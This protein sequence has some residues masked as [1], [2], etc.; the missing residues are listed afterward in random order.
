MSK[1]LQL[2]V[3]VTAV[4]SLTGCEEVIVAQPGSPDTGQPPGNPPAS[5]P[6]S[7]CPDSTDH[8][9]T[10]S[11]A[12]AA[13]PGMTDLVACPGDVDWYSVALTEGQ[14]LSV[15]VASSAADKLSL[16]VLE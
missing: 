1:H 16:S 10:A 14:Q 7:A 12:T 4:S 15:K 11:S 13:T 5:P 6:P 2:L 3:F 9:D 8:N